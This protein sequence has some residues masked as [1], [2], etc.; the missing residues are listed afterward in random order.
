VDFCWRSLKPADALHIRAV[1]WARHLS[2]PLMVT[3][4]V[5]WETINNL[6]KRADR[7]RAY[8]IVEMVDDSNYTIVHAAPEL[9]AAGLK[10][11]R[12][13]SDKEWSLTDC[14]SFHLMR[15]RGITLALAYDIHF[16][17]A[18]FEALLRRDPSV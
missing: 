14:I 7:L 13:R 3:E 18:G 17:Q 2:E 4:Y 15:E 5:L 11:H 8:R 10:L 6:S 12:A 9:F 16:E 1:A